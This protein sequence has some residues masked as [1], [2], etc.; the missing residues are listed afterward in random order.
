MAEQREQQ[1]GGEEDGE[2]DEPSTAADADAVWVEEEHTSVSWL[3]M[4][5]RLEKLVGNEKNKRVVC[6]IEGCSYM[7]YIIGKGSTSNAK[8]H[9]ST[10]HGISDTSPPTREHA[11]KGLKRPRGKSQTSL[12]D[13]SFRVKYTND[14][15]L[16][17]LRVILKL[18]L[19]FNHLDDPLMRNWV[20]SI[21]NDGYHLYSSTAI[22]TFLSLH[23]RRIVEDFKS[24]VR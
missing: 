19:A 3:Y 13:H 6:C 2:Q 20:K 12:L 17:V 10:A 22:K 23:H 8:T 24:K 9:L 21:S 7:H 18:K 16:D 14:T 15:K 5:M 4:H 11:V 1:Q